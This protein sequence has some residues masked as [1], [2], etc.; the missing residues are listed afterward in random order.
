MTAGRYHGRTRAATRAFLDARAALVR[1]L[2]RGVVPMRPDGKLPLLLAAHRI[3]EEHYKP[4]TTREKQSTYALAELWS[5]YSDDCLEDITRDK[6]QH[7]KT[8]MLARGNTAVTQIGKLSV[9]GVM[10]KHFDV[11]ERCCIPAPRVRKPLKWWLTPDMEA[12]VAAWCDKQQT[13]KAAT[14]RDYVRFIVRTGL[15]VQEALRLQRMHFTGLGTENPIMEVRG[16]KTKAA[17]RTLPLLRDAADI[18][19][20]RIGFEGDPE[21]YLFAGQRAYRKRGFNHGPEPLRYTILQTQWKACRAA[22]GIPVDG[23]TGLKALRRSFARV[24]SD[25][26]VPTEML[27]TYLGHEQI[28]TTQGY[29]HLIGRDNIERLRQWFR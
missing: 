29:L 19:I 7:W 5:L 8:V 15:R 27:Q 16:T 21:D 23:T 20:N 1:D 28:A 6:L 25:R 22:V 4:H 26:G 12:R 3:L 13:K 2:K 10:H 24:V 18:I 9:V 17:H 11:A 14:L